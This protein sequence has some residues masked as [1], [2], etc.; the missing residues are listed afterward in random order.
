MTLSRITA[1]AATAAIAAVPATALAHSSSKD[2]RSHHSKS[3]KSK[4]RSKVR[5]F[6]AA[7]ADPSSTT[8]PGSTG[9]PSSTTT[10]G[11]NPGADVAGTVVSFTNNVL[12]I[13]LNDGSSYSGTVTKDTELDCQTATAPVTATP[14]SG[15]NGA[16]NGE[17]GQGDHNTGDSR[18]GDSNISSRQGDNNGDNEQDD[19]TNAAAAPPCTT[20]SLKP[21]VKIHEAELFLKSTG[22]TWRKIEILQ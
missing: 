12:T 5:I 17:N 16:D 19:D 6:R 13:K 9:T 22:A 2:Q 20:D 21:A 1:L 18:R 15:D 11:T 14:R 7:S 10:P 4:K 3:K 8:T